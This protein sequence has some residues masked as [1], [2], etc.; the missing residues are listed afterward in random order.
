MVHRGLLDKY[1]C[2]ISYRKQANKKFVENHFNE[3]IDLY[4]AALEHTPLNHILF[5]NRAFCHLKLE[6]YGWLPHFPYGSRVALTIL[7]THSLALSLSLA[8]PLALA[9]ARARSLSLTHTHTS[10]HSTHTHTQIGSAIAD[11]TEAITLEPSYIKGYFRRGTAKLALGQLK[12]ARVDFRAACQI[13]PTNKEARSKLDECEKAI[14]KKAF[15]D[16]IQV[17]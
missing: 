15:E 11:A 5:A 4:T 14:K 13:E 9:R 12:P 10:C 6:N 16:A 7:L 8:P 3:S 2:M 17:Y 1:H